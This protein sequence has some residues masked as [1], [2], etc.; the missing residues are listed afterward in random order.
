[1]IIMGVMGLPAGAAWRRFLG[2]SRLETA[3]TGKDII[4]LPDQS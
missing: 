4:D 3:G 1:V 2:Q